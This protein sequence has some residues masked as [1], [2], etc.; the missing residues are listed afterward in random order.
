MQQKSIT[1]IYAIAVIVPITFAIRASNN[2]LATTV[3]LLV[4]YYCDFNSAEVG[5]LAAL[6]SLGSFITSGIL[7]SKLNYDG[8]KPVGS[9]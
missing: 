9:N 2:M 3:L 1:F 4:K 7:N 8:L 6:S 5:L